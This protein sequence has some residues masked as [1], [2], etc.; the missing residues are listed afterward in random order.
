TA[1]S[2]PDTTAAV[3]TTS[4]AMA[5]SPTPCAQVA[6]VGRHT[7]MEGVNL[8]AITSKEQDHEYR[9]DQRQVASAQGSRQDT[10]GQ[11]DRR[12]ADASRGERR[13]SR[14]ARSRAVR[15]REGTGAARSGSLL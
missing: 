2:S 7:A 13:P 3:P 15:L 14:G 8:G 12:R 9:S 10:V 11:A 4:M 5:T 1:I 6:P